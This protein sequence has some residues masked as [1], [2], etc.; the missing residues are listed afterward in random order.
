MLNNS[1]K[2]YLLNLIQM[3]LLSF[4]FFLF[5]NKTAQ[6]PTATIKPISTTGEEEN[7]DIDDHYLFFRSKKLLYDCKGNIYLLDSGNHRILVFDQNGI[8]VKKMGSV[9]QGPGE[10]LN[11]SDF[12]LIGDSLL[13]VADDGNNRI[14]ILDNSG[15]Y[16]SGFKLKF[17]PHNFE[18]EIDSKCRIY[19]NNPLSNHIF[20]I[21]S[22]EG[23]EIANLGKIIDY[24]NYQQ[25]LLFNDVHFVIDNDTLYACFINIPIFR[26]YTISGDLILAKKI[27]LPEISKVNNIYRSRI[28]K[29]PELVKSL[30]PNFFYSI[31]LG[32]DNY[33]YISVQ[34]TNYPLVRFDRN[35]NP[36]LRIIFKEK[37]ESQYGYMLHNFV[38]LNDYIFGF[39]V[40]NHV[41]RKFVNPK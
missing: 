5:C 2:F 39:D 20:T 16:K 28:N 7:R 27:D 21:F 10:L 22:L 15:N 13:V 1:K 32:Q 23:I 3:L 41:I 12:E 18:I 6:I 31:S 8:F 35:F 29:N 17:S 24:S 38:I 9:G 26:K 4:H 33:F 19:I 36:L 37:D 30:R 11:P 25:Q 34:G 14:Q 40:I